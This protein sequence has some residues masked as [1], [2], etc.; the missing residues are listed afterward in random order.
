MPTFV[1]WPLEPSPRP[2]VWL[3]RL[4]PPSDLAGRQPED[5]AGRVD[6]SLPR[7]DGQQGL[8]GCGAEVGDRP[9][10]IALIARLAAP[11]SPTDPLLTLAQRTL[12]RL[13]VQ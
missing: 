13:F 5:A 8:H 4:D 6:P 12:D 2:A 7:T 3:A 10:A 1:E 11:L 9:P